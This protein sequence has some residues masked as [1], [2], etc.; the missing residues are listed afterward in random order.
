M[1]VLS[2]KVW[3]SPGQWGSTA[4]I[5]FLIACVGGLVVNRASR[6]D[7]TYAFFIFYVASLFG[8]ALWLG[9]P[10]SI[11]L[12]QFQNGAF[13]IFAFFMIS[14]PKTT[15]DSRAGRIIF[16][17]LVATGSYVSHF[18]LHMT[19]GLLWSL[20]IF[21]LFVPFIDLLIKGEHF[22]WKKFKAYPSFN[23]QE[24]YP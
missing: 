24:A 18:I 13:L 19:N 23:K 1:L 3:V 9:D 11:P 4:F 22:E 14:D 5:G 8:R 20:M 21:A 7:V 16:A 12:H 6:S 10:I 17:F 2:D 15:P